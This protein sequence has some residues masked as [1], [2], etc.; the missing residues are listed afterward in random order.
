MTRITKQF[1]DKVV[2]KGGAP[3]LFWDDN[4]RG[5]G[6]LVLPSGTK[7][8]LA[9]Y[10]FRGRLRRQTIARHGV[11][12]PDQARDRARQILAQAADGKDPLAE[13]R[14]AAVAGMTMAQLAELYLKEGPGE[15]PNKK[16]SSWAV[17]LSNIRRHIKP[18]LGDWPMRQLTQADVAKF[19]S[20]V[21]LGR[22]KS[23]VRTKKRGR[24]MV[25]GGRG[26]AA[27]SLAVL[28]AMLEFAVRRKL[29]RANP[30]R[31]VPLLKLEPR[32]RFLSEREVGHLAETVNGLEAQG[33]VS[34][35]AA[36]AIRLL[37]L[38]GCRKS[39]ILSL[40]WDWVDLERGYLRLPD[41]KTGAKTVP[42][43]SAAVELLA[44]LPRR[45][46]YVLPAGKGSGHYVGLQKEWEEVREHAHLPGLRIH[47]LRHSFASFA[48]AGGVSLHITGKILGHRQART[49]EVY[50]H[51]ADDPL[52][53]AVE[54]TA[55]RI[56]AAMQNP[57]RRRSG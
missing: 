55:R 41:S 1:V 7:T 18:L 14:A 54:R 28:G 19:Q 31:G 24:A 23:D 56:V 22:S 44:G 57:A 21:A 33:T 53:Q 11:V 27:R 6:L 32:E 48:I 10:R 38:T 47:D 35:S 49:T 13:K 51:L 8:Y 39:E 37:L 34:R 2:A 25:S 20:D 16:A 12:T 42:L 4:L 43:A 3:T 17:D 5:F 50:A 15:K 45:S 36:A 26:T 29:I 30:A 52:R 9:N 46:P 40:R